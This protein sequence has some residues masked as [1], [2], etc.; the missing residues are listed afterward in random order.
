MHPKLKMIGKFRKK[1]NPNHQV[2]R[3]LLDIDIIKYNLDKMMIAY[4]DYS[5]QI[6]PLI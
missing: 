3:K 2:R 5:T 4:Y 6:V 1:D